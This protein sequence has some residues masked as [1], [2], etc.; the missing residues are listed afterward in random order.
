[1][2]LLTSGAGSVDPQTPAAEKPIKEKEGKRNNNWPKR[3]EESKSPKPK[4]ENR[5]KPAKLLTCDPAA[6][7]KGARA[8]WRERPEGLNP[9]ECRNGNARR[10]AFGRK[11]ENNKDL[12]NPDRMA[13]RDGKWPRNKE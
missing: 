3:K 6:A 10:P 5:R 1:M 12:P 2:D 7:M 11:E 9:A 4:T 13:T 8:G